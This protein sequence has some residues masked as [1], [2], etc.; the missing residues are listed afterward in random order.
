MRLGWFD[1]LAV[2]QNFGGVERSRGRRAY[3]KVPTEQTSMKISQEE[4]ASP[5]F[6]GR[7]ETKTAASRE[8]AQPP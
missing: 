6:H 5:W 1:A 4:S 8:A 2:C 7:S 3:A